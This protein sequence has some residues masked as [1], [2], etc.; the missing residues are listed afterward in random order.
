MKHANLSDAIIKAVRQNM[1][2]DRSAFD[3]TLFIK[4]N[5]AECLYD[6]ILNTKD[7]DEQ[8]KAIIEALK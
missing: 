6:I 1:E 7:P 2:F 5:V 3:S 4:I 8:L